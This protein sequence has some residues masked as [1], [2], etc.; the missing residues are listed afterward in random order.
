MHE[1]NTSRTL[2]SGPRNQSIEETTND[3]KVFSDKPEKNFCE[4]GESLLWNFREDV[5]RKERFEETLMLEEKRKLKKA[6][7]VLQLMLNIR[8]C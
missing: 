2:F 3:E 5:L 1:K 4:K 6:A 7:E 8:E